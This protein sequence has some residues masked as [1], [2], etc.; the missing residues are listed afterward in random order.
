MSTIG[1]HLNWGS[2]YIVND[3]YKRFARP[4]AS[5]K[6]LV[7]MGRI[8]T[9]ILM[10]LAAV[11]AL[12]FLN[13]ATQAFNI[14]LLSGAGSGAIYLLRWFW[15]RINAWTEIIALA[16]ATIVA[17][18]LVFFVDD[19]SIATRVLDGFTM[20]LLIAV[21]LTSIIWVITTLITKPENKKILR[22]FYKLTRPGG[23]GWKKVISDAAKDGEIINEAD[24]GKPWEMPIQILLVFIGCIVIY[25][26]LFAI[27]NF[28]YGE[29]LYGLILITIAGIGTYLL[30]KSF[31]KLRAN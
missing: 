3:F 27:G 11:V 17:V 10:I 28:V 20:K 8:S 14:L 19:A 12:F 4:D 22:E 15:W 2:S 30:F 1:T 24:L 23:P 21:T 7:L 16:G 6:E 29:T 18:I 25:S 26:S 9:L 13:N 5:E 31:S